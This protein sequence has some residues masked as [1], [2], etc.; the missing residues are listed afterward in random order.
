M[1]HTEF[2]TLLNEWSFTFTILY[3]SVRGV[4][5]KRENLRFTHY[6]HQKSIQSIIIVGCL[7]N[8]IN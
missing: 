1:A 5:A 8:M 7:L 3:A 4:Y 2:F 6:Q